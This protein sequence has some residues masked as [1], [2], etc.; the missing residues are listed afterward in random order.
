VDGDA[1][2]NTIL[3]AIAISIFELRFLNCVLPHRPFLLRLNHEN[4]NPM[5]N[6][7]VSRPL[8]LLNHFRG[9]AKESVQ[10]ISTQLKPWA[11]PILD[12][13]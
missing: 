3:T 4:L 13:V 8:E 7:P 12:A 9:L 11:N 6:S 1:L 5:L 10:L 2:L